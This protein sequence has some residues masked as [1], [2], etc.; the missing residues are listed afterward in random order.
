MPVAGDRATPTTEVGHTQGAA[1]GSVRARRAISKRS[2][3][4]TVQAL[5]GAFIDIVGGGIV[6]VALTKSDEVP[7]ETAVAV[8]RQ[9]KHEAEGCLGRPLLAE[10]H[11]QLVATWKAR[12]G[13][14]LDFA[15]LPAQRRRP[16]SISL[17]ARSAWTRAT[18]RLSKRSTS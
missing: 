12:A 11:I 18:E 9:L 3:I 4:A 1:D 6:R 17:R 14:S 5:V 8:L 13:L 7:D 2:W 16:A 15:P 10:R